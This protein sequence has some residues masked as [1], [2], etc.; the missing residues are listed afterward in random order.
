MARYLSQIDVWATAFGCIV[1]WGAF[2]MPGT[3]FLPVAG[4]IG[5]TAAM[6]ISAIIMLVIGANYAYLMVHH[7][8]TG[9]VYT[10]CREAFGRD[11]AFL[12]SWFLSLSYTSIVFLNA[13]ALFVVSRTLF[14][15]ALQ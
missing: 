5:T 15:T 4:P 13:T 2:V 9:G 14:G 10:Y 3:T 7:P 1:G 6:I 12:C 8:G 11:H